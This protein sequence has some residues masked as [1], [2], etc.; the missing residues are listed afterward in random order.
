MSEID[1]TRLTQS[2]AFWTFCDQ[3]QAFLSVHWGWFHEWFH[4]F[5]VGAVVSLVNETT[6]VKASGHSG[7]SGL[8][9]VLPF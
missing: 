2:A 7:T 3:S 9:L 4:E 6:V 8:P 5:G 1:D